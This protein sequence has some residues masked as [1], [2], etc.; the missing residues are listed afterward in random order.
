MSSYVRNSLWILVEKILV[1]GG[2]L[3]V[4]IIVSNYL[5]AKEFGKIAFGV[6]LASIPMTLSQWGANHTISN[7]TI[8]K[9]SQAIRYIHATTK[10]RTLIYIIVTLIVCLVLYVTPQYQND[11]LL[12]FMVMISHVYLGMDISQYYFNARLESKVNA[13]SSLYSKLLSVA[14]RGGLVL[15]KVNPIWF[16]IPYLMNNYIVYKMRY[17]RIPKLKY[18]SRRYETSYLL[19]G[20]G[21]TVSAFFTIVY[22]KINEIFL[23]NILGYSEIAIFNVA[24][25]LGFAWA[26]IPQA[27]GLSFLT[28]ALK[29]TDNNRRIDVFSFV[30]LLMIIVSIPA[31][32]FY[33]LFSAYFV[34]FLFKSEYIMAAEILPILSL[35]C[36]LSALGV[37]NNRVIGSYKGGSS[38]L[39]KKVMVCASISGVISYALI[40]QFGLLGA[41]YSL[42]ITEFISLSIANYFFSSGVILRMHTKLFSIYYW[43]SL[44]HTGF[45]NLL[46]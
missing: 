22:S 6:T 36:L 2:G 18:K 20:K 8:N 34:S 14:M 29:V 13:I 43:R 45:E 11:L 5:G 4:Y 9:P 19:L 23:A 39:Y 3:V 31:V 32:I 27:I 44:Q 40:N 37:I 35:C 41:A 38:Y 42:L 17:S 24:L 16:F 10:L 21:F 15:L 1:L 30:F 12:L 26:F 46:R 28:K 25:T 7:M 33:Y